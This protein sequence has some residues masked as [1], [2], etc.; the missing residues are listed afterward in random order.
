MKKSILEFWV[1]LFVLLGVVAIGFLA[2]RVA[3]GAAVGGGS[4]KTYT[5]YADFT[6]IGG[7]RVNAPV[8]AAGVLVGRVGGIQLDPK[9]YQAKVSLN[10]NSQYQFSSDVSAQILTSGLLGEQY[11]GLMQGGDEEELVAGDTITVTGSA[12]VL[13]NLIGKFM[14]NFAEQNAG[15]KKAGESSPA[16]SE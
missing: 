7:L 12:I 14:T 15:S 5:V 4:G 11:I 10:L 13:E 8:K 6:D 9:T 1:G 3:G 2:F 16:A